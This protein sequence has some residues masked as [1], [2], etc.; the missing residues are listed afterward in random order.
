[1]CKQVRPQ[2]EYVVTTEVLLFLITR[3]SKKAEMKMKKLLLIPLGVM[4]ICLHSMTVQAGQS[5]RALL[6]F[7][8]N[9]LAASINSSR[10]MLLN[11]FI[12]AFLGSKSNFPVCCFVGACVRGPEPLADK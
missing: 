10:V 2:T 8:A 11:P 12:K 7:F 3:L 5:L 1:V 6:S 9:N 4:F